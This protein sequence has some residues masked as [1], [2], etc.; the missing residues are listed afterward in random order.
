MRKL[1]GITRDNKGLNRLKRG[2][3]LVEWRRKVSEQLGRAFDKY[4]D[5]L[6][7]ELSSKI[8]S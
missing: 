7:K 5:D 4:V 3:E 2:R 6:L 1:H 8:P